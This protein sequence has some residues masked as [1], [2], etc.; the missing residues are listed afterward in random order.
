M[1]ECGLCRHAVFRHASFP[2]VC[3]SV[4]FVHS[5]E[6]NK[7]I[8]NFFSPSSSQA[9]LV[10]SHQT[11]WHDFYGNPPKRG[12]QTQ[13]GMKKWRFSTNISLYLPNGAKH[14][15]SYYGRRI[16]TAPKLSNG[17]SFN[18]IEWPLRKISRSQ[19]YSTSSNS[20][21]VQDRAIFTM[22]DQ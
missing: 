17:T 1:H 9:I 15:H 14:S 21:M 10:S 16:K 22:A 6:T 11:P 2:F 8:F 18:D 7:H 4:T 19:Y 12:W 13:G 5:V 20:K 3:P